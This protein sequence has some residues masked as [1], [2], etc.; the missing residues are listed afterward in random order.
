M[1]ELSSTTGAV[2]L[3]AAGV[4]LIALIWVVVLTVQIRRLK[5][6]Q[7]TVLG[8]YV[9]PSGEPVWTSTLVD[10]LEFTNRSRGGGI[11]LFPFGMSSGPALA[12]RGSF[13]RL[14]DIRIRFEGP[15][16]VAAYDLT[17]ARAIDGAG[18]RAAP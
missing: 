5:A 4:A 9:L 7:A 15:A 11:T 14:P 12:L 8:E 6:A 1:D 17:D 2:A 10:V 16:P 3:A 18:G 13:E